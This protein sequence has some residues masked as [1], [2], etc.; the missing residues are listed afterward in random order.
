MEQSLSWEVDSS[1]THQE[2]SQLFMEPEGI[3]LYLQE[4][5]T[6]LYPTTNHSSLYTPPPN[7]FA[8]LF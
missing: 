8:D 6:S 3:S 5:T 2:I 7:P 4:P 1:S